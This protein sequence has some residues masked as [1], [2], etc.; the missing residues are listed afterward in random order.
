MRRVSVFVGS[1]GEQNA[2]ALARSVLEL[3]F[4]SSAAL[5]PILL[6]CVTE[7]AVNVILFV[8]ALVREAVAET[9]VRTSV[10]VCISWGTDGERCRGIPM[11]RRCAPSS[12]ASSRRLP[13]RIALMV[14][15]AG[16]EFP[17]CRADAYRLPVISR[18]AMPERRYCCGTLKHQSS[19]WYFSSLSSLRCHPR[20]ALLTNVPNHFRSDR[21]S[22]FHPFFV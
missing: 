17:V 8:P 14:S 3:T 20:G 6:W 4:I 18:I 7:D 22:G 10:P 2:V 9:A 5:L 13:A 16:R 19:C 11:C 12:G 1:D 21:W 15:F